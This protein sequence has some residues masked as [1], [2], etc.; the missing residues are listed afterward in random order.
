MKALKT[1]LDLFT[2]PEA[3]EITITTEGFGIWFAWENELNPHV[4]QIFQDYSGLFVREHEGQALWF[5]FSSDVLLALAKLSAWAK[6]NSMSINMQVIPA[7]LHI[8]VHKQVM[9]EVAPEYR[10]QAFLP[11]S[12]GLYC[13]V[14]DSLKRAGQ[15]IPGLSFLEKESFEADIDNYY[16][17]LTTERIYKLVVD[18]KLPYN[19][20]AGWYAIIHPLG[21]PFDKQFQQGWR[22]MFAMFEGI[23]EKNKL[24][25]SL[26]ETFLIIFL[27]HFSQLKTWT[28]DI[29]SSIFN[30]KDNRSGDYW[31]CVNVVVDRKGLNFSNDLP[32][33]L[34]IKWDRISPD[35]MHMSYRNA[36]PLGSDFSVQD[37]YFTS[38]TSSI[39]NMCSVTLSSRDLFATKVPIL[40]PGQFV[41]GSDV[42]CFYCGIKSHAPAK[43][44]TR[45]LK[46]SEF[47]FWQNFND[48]DI[49]SLNLA[50]R[51]IE[52]SISQSGSAKYTE[53]LNG[54]DTEK[55]VLE[56]IFQTNS[57]IQVRAIERIWQLFDKNINS[58]VIPSY[59]KDDSPAWKLLTNFISVRQEELLLFEKNALQTAADHQRDWKIKSLLGFVALERGDYDK[60]MAYWRAA[61]SNCSSILHQAWHFFLQARLLEITGKYKE[62]YDLYDDTKKLLPEWYEPHYRKYVCKVKLAKVDEIL[63]ELIEEIQ[64]NPTLFNR[65]ILDPE[66]ERGQLILLTALYPLWADS[67][68]FSALEQDA[69]HKLLEEVNQ[70]FPEDDHY[71]ALAIRTKLEELIRGISVQNFLASSNITKFRPIIEEQFNQLKRIEISNIKKKYKAYLTELEIIRDEASWFP[72]PRTLIDFNKDFNEC[73]GLLNWA[74]GANFDMPEPFNQAQKSVISITELLTRLKNKLKFIRTVRDSTL[75]GLIFL[76][77]FI[78]LGAGLLAIALLLVIVI[79]L[80]GS[81]I[82]LGWLQKLMAQN[83]WDLQKT[84]LIVIGVSSLGVASIRA[85]LVFEKRRDKMVADAKAARE[86]MQQKRLERIRNAQL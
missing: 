6:Y 40:L 11:P 4:T 42:P 18:S 52:M 80:F 69:L 21:S 41:T 12:K 34:P 48:L 63:P 82:G 62:A 20:P 47:D 13:L 3:S 51:N 68:K 25:Y 67:L 71:V 78:W 64:A 84:L 33:K 14:P 85:T 75:Y 38:G 31:P 23:I 43:C 49:D 61:E 56:A 58:S 60:A 35:L 86:E 15:N 9:L 22:S 45:T 32:L 65:V 24:K 81:S 7:T 2:I 53:L 55:R 10:N 17:K 28:D 59:S 16:S 8:D 74:F 30:L 70:W 54:D 39:D 46:E 26:H 57:A 36:Y 50:F 77:T 83:F 1:I 5:F 79:T 19:S 72:F 29:L 37:M 76:K 73:A 66:F 27:D 44:P